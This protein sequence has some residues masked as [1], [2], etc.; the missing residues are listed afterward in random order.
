[1]TLMVLVLLPVI[2]FRQRQQLWEDRGAIA[3]H[4]I[5]PLCRIPAR[6]RNKRRWQARIDIFAGAALRSTINNVGQTLVADTVDEW[7]QEAKW[8]F[9]CRK[10]NAIK[11]CNNG[12]KGRRRGTKEDLATSQAI[13]WDVYAHLVPPTRISLP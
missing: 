11:I 4:R 3:S 12:C 2:Q 9:A 5:P 8:W 6:T 7:V 13:P 10:A 1:M